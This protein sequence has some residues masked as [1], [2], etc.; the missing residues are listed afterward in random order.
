MKELYNSL[1]IYKIVMYAS[2]LDE[3]IL[4]IGH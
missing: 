3:G 1:G 4:S 2:F